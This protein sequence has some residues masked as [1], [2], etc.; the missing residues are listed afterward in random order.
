MTGTVLPT[1]AADPAPGTAELRV[2]LPAGLAAGADRLAGALGVPADRPLLAAYLRVVGLLA[3]TP[4]VTVGYGSGGVR[5]DLTGTWRDLLRGPYREVAGGCDA[6]FAGPGATLAVVPAGDHVLVRHRL[7]RVDAAHAERIGG[8]LVRALGA[9]VADPDA[10]VGADGL[11][12]AAERAVQLTGLAGPDRP[13]PDRRVADLVAEQARRTPAAVAAVQGD[14]SWTYAELDRAADAVAAGLL[15]AGVA[16]EEVVAVVTG[17]TLEWLAAIL[18]TFR[19]GGAYLPVEPEFPAERVR[20]LLDRGGCR[21]ALAEGP[22]PGLG[23]VRRLDVPDLLATGARADPPPV[24]AGALAYVYFTSGST[25]QPKGAMCEHLG[26]LNHLLAKVEDLDLGPGDV[27][28]QN[29]GQCFDI[30]LWQLV[31]PLL[32]GGRTLLVD[33]DTILDPARFLDTVVAGGATV[34]Q[35]VPSYLDVLL[36]QLEDRPRDLGRLRAV[37]VTGE[38]VGKALVTRW[39]AARPGIALV[40]AYGATEASDDTTHEVLTAPPAE[41]LVPV[42][43]PVRNVTVTVLGPADELL[44]LGAVGEIT[45]SGVCVGRGYVNDPERTAEAFGPDPHRPGVRLYRTGDYGRWLPTGALEFRGRRDEQV[46]VHG[47]R[48]EL[49]EVESRVLDHP[50]VTAAA[51]VAAPLPGGGK[52]LVAYFT[53]PAGLAPA[54]LHAHLARVLPASSVPARLEPLAALPL[55]A[56]GKVDKKALV[57]R[58]A[59]PEATAAAGP[60]PLTGTEARI[61]AAWARALDRPVDSIGRDDSFFDLGGSSLA[62]LRMVVSLDGL[63]S[64]ADLLAAPVLR[65]LAAAAADPAAAGVVPVGEAG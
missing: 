5:A 53:A 48:I 65:D 44:P 10:G 26:M 51:V 32:V 58:A 29:A 13:L 42:G 54:D 1:W 45:F 35:V 41:E 11:V 43:R 8:Y 63:V 59:V 40:N 20:T 37:S 27:V 38:A 12:G 22:G 61:A 39:F 24:P 49:G 19:A 56:N 50:A 31:A 55:T 6:G 60:R 9:A 36:R 34:L 17:R 2:P 46:K 4:T 14:R 7:D 64:L 18:G 47:I 21:L 15:A 3:G 25:G 30:S 28:V 57:A 33:R 62:A 52:A 16:G 23:S